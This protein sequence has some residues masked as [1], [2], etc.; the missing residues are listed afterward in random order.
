MRNTKNANMGFA[1]REVSDALLVSLIDSTTKR[2]EATVRD[3][4]DDLLPA[5]LCYTLES[6]RL[7]RASINTDIPTE[8]E[9]VIMPRFSAGELSRW[10]FWVSSH[11]YAT[12]GNE[13]GRSFMF[14]LLSGLILQSEEHLKRLAEG[15]CD[16]PP[17]SSTDSVGV[18][19]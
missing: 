16:L 18:V 19:S 11:T 5:W 8:P 1:V 10:L 12:G 4:H 17:A 15:N 2:H 7:R 9:A 14:A 3:G 6:E 13:P